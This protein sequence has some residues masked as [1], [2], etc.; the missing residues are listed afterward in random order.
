MKNLALKRIQ[1]MKPYTPPLDGRT[2]SRDLLLDFNERTL[3]PAD[4]VTAALQRFVDDRTVQ[5]YPEY[6]NLEAE[7]ARYAGVAAEQIMLTNGT[8]QAIDVIFRTFAD[9]GDTVIIPE[10]SFAMYRQTAQV[11]GQRIVS[12]LYAKTDLAFPLK[13]VLAAITPDVKLIVVCNPNSPTGTLLPVDDIARIA[14]RAKDAIVYV[15]E[16]YFEFSGSSAAGLIAKYPNIIVSRT[17]SKAFGLAG[18]RIGY[19]IADKRYITEMLKVRGPYDVNRPACYA[20]SAALA[21]VQNV[22]AY[23]DEVM[24]R[25]KPMVEAFFARNNVRFYPSAGNFI[26]L[27]PDNPEQVAA[28]LKQ[29]GILVRPQDKPNIR[30]SFRL[31]IGTVAQMQSFIR[32]YQTA[33]LGT[34]GQK[35]AFLDRDGT[36][37]FEPE[38]DF[39]VDSLDKL[40]ILDGAIGGLTQLVNRGYKLAMITNQNGVG[41]PAFPAEAFELPQQAMLEVFGKAGIT[42]DKVFVCPHFEEDQCDCRKP[43]TG[44]LDEFLRTAD[45]DLANS[46][47]CGD[48]ESDKGLAA[49]IGAAFVPMTTNGNFEQ[50]IKPFIR[51]TS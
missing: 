37:I 34:A 14:R 38:D 22:R 42:F 8:D 33:V 3:P 24:N 4:E 44:L 10:P 50:A 36:L 30:G 51:S 41:T 6:W 23:A 31:T 1:A 49:A 11:A 16:A 19:A 21:S 35:Y 2:E 13:Q 15:D 40:Q 47:V 7:V 28:K 17:F 45:I 27:Q 46:F 26:L 20:A 9:R 12:P 43:K 18:L 39:Q 29:N 48:R 5:V 25:A 32:T